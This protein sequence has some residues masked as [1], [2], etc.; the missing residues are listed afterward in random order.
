MVCLKRPYFFVGLRLYSTKMYLVHSWIICLV[1][2]IRA[3]YFWL[4]ALFEEVEVLLVHFRVSMMEL[5]KQNV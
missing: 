4:V 5:L 3:K 2:L 1:S